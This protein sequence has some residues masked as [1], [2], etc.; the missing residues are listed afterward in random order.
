M[1]DSK[2][3]KKIDLRVIGLN[4]RFVFGLMARIFFHIADT[5]NPH[6]FPISETVSDKCVLTEGQIKIIRKKWAKN[7]I[8]QITVWAVRK[9]AMITFLSTPVVSPFVVFAVIDKQ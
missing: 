5:L 1:V 3:N 8:V 4:N 7:R 2:K 9:W 6:K